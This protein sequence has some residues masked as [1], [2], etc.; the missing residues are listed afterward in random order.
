M[1]IY[2]HAY[3]FIHPFRHCLDS[4][5]LRKLLCTA[6]DLISS[7][8]GCI[9]QRDLRIHVT[10]PVCFTAM[11]D[12][13]NCAAFLG[14]VCCYFLNR[15]VHFC[16]VDKTGKKCPRHTLMKGHKPYLE[17]RISQRLA[18]AGLFSCNTVRHLLRNHSKHPS[19]HPKLPGNTLT[20]I[21]NVLT[22]WQ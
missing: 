18:S 8:A 17:T 6:Q 19:N 4:N 22:S 16:Q 11:N 7:G 12:T 1:S 2:I 20:S 10:H 21:H 5:E 14:E 15:S 13:S 3:F 9:V